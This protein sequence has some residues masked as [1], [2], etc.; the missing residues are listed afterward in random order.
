MN[1]GIGI[2]IVDIKKFKKITY[3]SK[4]HFYEKLFLK[5]EIDYCLRFKNSAERFAGKFAVKE[6]VIKSISGKISFLDI[7]TLHSNDKPIV[8]LRNKKQ[9]YNFLVSISH[10][11]NF[12]ISVVISKK[13]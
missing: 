1:E 11:K 4:P 12:A 9:K 6:A 8:K 2:D 10:E 5:S 7:E 3:S 13:I